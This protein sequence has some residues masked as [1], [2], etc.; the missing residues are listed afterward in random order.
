MIL[1]YL[2][3]NFIKYLCTFQLSEKEI[4]KINSKFFPLLLKKR[5]TFC[6]IGQHCNCLGILME[7]LLYASYKNSETEE[8]VSRFFY[9]PD[10]FIVSSFESFFHR[11]EVNETITAIEDS[12]FFCI[13]HDDLETL[14]K[15]VPQMNS[16]VRKLVEQSYVKAMQR[17]YILQTMDPK[18]RVE[19]FFTE[20]RQLIGRLQVYHISS[21]LA[22][23]RNRYTEYIKVVNKWE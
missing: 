8:I 12:Q 22:M 14:Y 2:N 10:N 21:Y 19:K 1:E 16:I 4:R 9:V 6:E 15:E 18:Q 13:S 23:H 11:V 5:E 3:D 20:H 17:L 7:G